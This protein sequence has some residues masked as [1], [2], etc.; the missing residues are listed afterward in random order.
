VKKADPHSG[1]T[2]MSE[3]PGAELEA[4]FDRARAD[5]FSG[6]ET[7]ELWGR[8]GAALAAPVAGAS[9]SGAGGSGASTAGG[10]SL[11]LKIAVALV[12]GGGVVAGA[13]AYRGRAPTSASVVAV[14]PARTEVASAPVGP[15][16]PAPAV[17]I[18]ELPRVSA[19]APVGAKTRPIT[20]RRDTVRTAAPRAIDTPESTSPAPEPAL[21]ARTESTSPALEADSPPTRTNAA[22]G[23]SPSDSTAVQQRGA[24]P[25]TVQLDVGPTEGALLL[26][27]RQELSSDP[28]DAL[29]LTQEHA[30]RFPSGT[31][32]QEREVLA[33]EALARLGRSPEARRRLDAFRARFPQS[34]HISRLSA[35]VGP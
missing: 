32:V 14:H 11:G 26:R 12:V 6:S 27:A 34:P 8:V 3:A 35:L 30:R 21:A 17:P 1:D 23:S 33:I 2:V 4:L 15:A 7:D 16:T 28:S 9:A 22:A 29:A 5:G 25:S 18:D 19:P 20:E 24:T 31:L 13:A 10:A